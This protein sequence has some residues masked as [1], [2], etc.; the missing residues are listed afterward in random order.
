MDNKLI[1]Q[2]FKWVIIVICSTSILLIFCAN[3]GAKSKARKMT[4]GI[5]DLF[6]NL[7]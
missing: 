2:V 7:Y 1:G 6:E 5:I 3:Y 4:T